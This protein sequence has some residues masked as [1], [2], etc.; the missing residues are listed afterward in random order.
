MKQDFSFLPIN[1]FLFF[2]L[3]LKLFRFVL[4]YFGEF[5][6]VTFCLPWSASFSSYLLDYAE[7]N[8]ILLCFSFSF[9]FTYNVIW[10]STLVA[11]YF[12][13]YSVWSQ[14]FRQGVFISFSFIISS[15]DFDFVFYSCI[16]RFVYLF[17]YI[18][19]RSFIYFLKFCLPTWV[20]NYAFGASRFGLF[21]QSLFLVS[22][23]NWFRIF[24]FL[25]SPKFFKQDFPVFFSFYHFLSS[26]YST[27]K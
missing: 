26:F 6:F 12:I 13:M 19:I 8:S 17:I 24:I 22:S 10:H 5:I 20:F 27:K 4:F 11:F 9:F 14:I 2:F 3:G 7:G 18:F 1:I 25:F 21:S 23:I 16:F 15:S